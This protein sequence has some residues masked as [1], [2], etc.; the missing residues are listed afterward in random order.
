[1]QTIIAGLVA[2]LKRERAKNRHLRHILA[3]IQGQKHPAGD[4]HDNDHDQDDIVDATVYPFPPL[5]LVPPM[6]MSLDI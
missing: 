6:Q 3:T 4:S 5:Q 2:D 1:M